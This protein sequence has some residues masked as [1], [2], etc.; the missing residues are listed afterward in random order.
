M[1]YRKEGI[2]V[3]GLRFLLTFLRAS[4]FVGRRATL[5][6]TGI[7]LQEDSICRKDLGLRLEQVYEYEDGGDNILT[8]RGLGYCYTVYLWRYFVDSHD[9]IV[10]RSTVWKWEL[11]HVFVCVL[12]CA[13][14]FHHSS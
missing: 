11:L 6:M 2:T 8:V 3:Y 5:Y 7:V 14:S 10:Q 9:R 1:A 12:G 4:G 13:S